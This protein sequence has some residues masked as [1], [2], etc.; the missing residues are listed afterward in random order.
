MLNGVIC[1]AMPPE[2]TSRLDSIDFIRGVALLGI[3]M[4]NII[5]FSMPEAAYFVPQQF[6]AYSW[7]NLDGLNGVVQSGAHFLFEGKFISI[8]AMLFG[9]SILVLRERAVGAGKGRWPHFARMF[10]LMAIGLFHAYLIWYG[11]ILFMYGLMGLIAVLFV[12]LRTSTKVI[13]GLLAFLVPLGLLLLM[14]LGLLALDSQRDAMRG[15]GPSRGLAQSIDEIRAEFS[16]EPHEIEAEIK[17][18]QGGYASHLPLRATTAFYIQ[19]SGPLLF[20]GPVLGLMLLGMALFKAG[21][22]TSPLNAKSFVMCVVLLVAGFAMQSLSNLGNQRTHY[23]PMHVQLVWYPLFTMGT[24]LVA[25]AYAKMLATLALNLPTG[26]TKWFTNVG[27]LSLSNYLLQSVV[28]TLLFYGHGLGWFATVDRVG[29]VPIVLGVWVLNI[30]FSAA[31]MSRFKIGP[32]EW[33]YRGAARA[34]GG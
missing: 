7:G 27:R 11:D 17:A 1:S 2:K 18:Y 29:L 12:F 15:E 32:I 34:I 20:G 25:V 6:T 16:Y 23:E 8:F 33:V 9:V 4:M 13:V 26:V 14:G 3:L 24:P 22:F 10:V 21:W 5:S 28:C 30:V 31:W 19:L